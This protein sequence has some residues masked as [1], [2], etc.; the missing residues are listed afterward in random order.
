MLQ[1]LSDHIADAHMRAAEWQERARE[2]SNERERI[3][4]LRLAKSWTHLAKSYSFIEELEKFLLDAHRARW[5][6]IDVEKMPVFPDD[7]YAGT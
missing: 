2:V 5:A 6:P 1:K 4:S 7:D 3:A